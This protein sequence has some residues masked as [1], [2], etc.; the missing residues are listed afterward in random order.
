MQEDNLEHKLAAEAKHQEDSLNDGG[1]V[2]Q[3]QVI[4]PKLQV[5]GGGSAD[6][7]ITTKIQYQVT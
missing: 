1:K 7:K 5:S 4:P 3:E 6:I 2:V